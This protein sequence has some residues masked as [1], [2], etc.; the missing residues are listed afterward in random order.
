MHTHFDWIEEKM[1]NSQHNDTFESE[2]IR[3]TKLLENL[4]DSW[5]KLDIEYSKKFNKKYV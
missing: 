5:E 1:N 4:L 2:C 3:R